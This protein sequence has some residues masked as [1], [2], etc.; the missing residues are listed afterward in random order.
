MIPR[1]E[2]RK[3]RH[4]WLWMACLL[5]V[6]PLLAQ[7]V[8]LNL[9]DADINALIG[10]VAFSGSMI[11]FAKLQGIMRKTWRFAAQQMINLATFVVLLGLGALVAMGDA[12]ATV[13]IIFFLVALATPGGWWTTRRRCAGSPGGCWSGRGPSCWRPRTA[14][15]SN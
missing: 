2:E 15:A 1:I 3:S 4:H 12:G 10:T 5:W 13:T 7:T 11:A 8:T 9:K 6:G 14:C